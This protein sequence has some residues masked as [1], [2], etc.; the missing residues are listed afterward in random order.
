MA[1]KSLAHPEDD[2]AWYGQPEAPTQ[3]VIK[4]Y[5]HRLEALLKTWTRA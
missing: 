2:F 4:V 5:K 1:A 3:I